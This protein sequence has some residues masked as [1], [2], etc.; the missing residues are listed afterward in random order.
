[1][2]SVIPR[3]LRTALMVQSLRIEV[4]KEPEG[5]VFL[6]MLTQ[7]DYWD[8]RYEFYHTPNVDG[9]PDDIL[10]SDSQDKIYHSFHG[11]EMLISWYFPGTFVSEEKVKKLM[12]KWNAGPTRR[13]I[14]YMLVY[15]TEIKKLIV[16]RK[17]D[18]DGK[19][20]YEEG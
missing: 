12:D 13:P 8:L 6:V 3:N 2:G 9:M 19:L 5:T 7:H 16:V 1:M 10:P 15:G 4:E 14:Q 20:L 17:F 18:T 11:R